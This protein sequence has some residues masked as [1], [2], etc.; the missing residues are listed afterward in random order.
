MAES[1]MAAARAAQSRIRRREGF[2][3]SLK[4]LCGETAN[5]RYSMTAFAGRPKPTI[6]SIRGLGPI[7][8]AS[9]RCPASDYKQESQ[10][11]RTREVA[12]PTYIGSGPTRL[13]GS[14]PPLQAL[15]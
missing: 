3:V 15:R 9:G 1:A 6:G 2:M 13:K 11:A 5:G 7:R 8:L 14:C 10:R 12:R 4:R